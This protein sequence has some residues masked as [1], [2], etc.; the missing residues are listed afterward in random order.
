MHE[1]AY[2]CVCICACVC[3]L[4][5]S[6]KEREL[7]RNVTSLPTNC[8]IPGEASY[9]STRHSF[10]LPLHCVCLAAQPQTLWAKSQCI[11]YSQG[12]Q[13]WAGLGLSPNSFQE[14]LTI[15]ILLGESLLLKPPTLIL[16]DQ[17]WPR[18]KRQ[19][20]SEYLIISHPILSPFKP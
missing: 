5:T 12:S 11:P 14:V 6:W 15:N 1:Y 9:T 19:I 7:E 16:E 17:N 18:V 2:A 20:Y 10:L 8:F 4:S 13:G 3:V